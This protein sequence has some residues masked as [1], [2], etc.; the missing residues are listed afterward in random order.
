[1]DVQ[2]ILIC[3]LSALVMGW[4]LAGAVF[5]AMCKN[6]LKKIDRNGHIEIGNRLFEVREILKTRYPL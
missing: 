3:V 5:S 2:T 4:A 1:M 6:M